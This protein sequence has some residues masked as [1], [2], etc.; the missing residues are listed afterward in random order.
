MNDLSEYAPMPG[1]A[2]AITKV[3]KFGWTIKDEPGLFM[4]VN[5]NEINIH[6]AYQRPL[7]NAKVLEIAKAWSWMAAGIIIIGERGNEF[8]AIDGQHRVAAA[9]KRHDI[10]E[11]P[12]LIFSTESVEQEAQGFLDVNT[13]RKPVS[14]LAKFTASI[15]AGDENSRFVHALLSEVGITAKAV[16]SGRKEL[17]SIAWAISRSKENR[18][19]FEVVVR[20]VSELCEECSVSEWLLDGLYYLHV[21][22][23]S[24]TDKKTRERLVKV[25][26]PRLVEAAKRASA[27]YARGGAKIWGTGMLDEFNKGFRTKVALTCASDRVQQPT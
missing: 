26:A 3:E 15:S 4:M 16:A 9:K 8:W 20:L 19:A 1:K 7:N 14:G 5:K 25:G 24:L 18:P 11:L 23:L 22:G 12:C 17:K 13:G 27:Y 6:P 10:Q 2:R 21:N